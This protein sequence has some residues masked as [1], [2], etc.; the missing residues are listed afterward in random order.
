MT[1]TDVP[2]NDAVLAPA[3]TDQPLVVMPTAASEGETRHVHLEPEP[4]AWPTL[5][6]LLL[7]GFTP[8][9]SITLTRSSGV[10]Y[11]HHLPMAAFAALLACA[12]LFVS[13]KHASA[14][15]QVLYRLP[16]NVAVLL[17]LVFDLTIIFAELTNVLVPEAGLGITMWCLLIGLGAASAWLNVQYL[18]RPH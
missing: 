7:G 3:N 10:L 16:P 4:R 11:E 18:R 15:I 12:I 9:L 6:Q 1:T 17:A 2:T 5:E 8:L 13:I 14:S